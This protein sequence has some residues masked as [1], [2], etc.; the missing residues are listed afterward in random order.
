MKFFPVIG[1]IS[2]IPEVKR[3]HRIGL[4]LVVSLY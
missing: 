3:S 4:N 1:D 2:T